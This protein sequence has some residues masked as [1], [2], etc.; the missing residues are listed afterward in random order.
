MN[1]SE[2]I[3]QLRQATQAG[4]M[5]CKKALE[6]TDYD[7]N[8]A[9]KLLRE[10]GIAKAAEKNL[11][12]LATEGT[13]WSGSDHHGAA[14]I[15]LNAQTDFTGQSELVLNLAQEILSLVLNN[16]T[17]DLTTIL[18]VKLSDGQTV[19][20]ACLAASAKTGEKIELRRIYYSPIADDQSVGVY[21]HDNGKISSLI[22]VNGQA[23]LDQLKGVAMHI[24]AMNPKFLD[25]SRVDQAW[26]ASEKAIL[27]AQLTAEGKD[28]RFSEK[29]IAGRM[30]KLLSEI[31]LLNQEYIL[32]PKTSVGSYLQSL[33]VTAL[34]MAR[35]ELGEGME[36][37]VVD[38]ASE[39]KAQMR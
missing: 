27:T 8:Q 22:I 34:E 32:M 24:T 30:Q 14:L 21:R 16:K 20:D 9:V 11:N 7:L 5:D 13:T 10:K 33:G 19:S 37:V 4:F 1:K 29:I 2:L 23:T 38:F 35:F 36:K 6:A 28:P 26:L 31:C 39:V 3:K 12:K 25:P 15:E 18:A 17:D